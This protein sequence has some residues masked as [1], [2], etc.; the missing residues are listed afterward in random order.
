M[1]PRALSTGLVLLPVAD[2]LPGERRW[3][4]MRLT[5]W[6]TCCFLV[7]F[8]FQLQMAVFGLGLLIFLAIP[9]ERWIRQ[10]GPAMAA[11]VPVPILQQLFGRGS[12]AW[13]EAAR[14]RSQH[15]LVL[16]EWYEWLGII[17]PMFL[18]W[19]WS[20]I[21]DRRQERV[22]AWFNRRI[23][24]YS[25]LVLAL[26]GA[27]ILPPAF[28]RITP[29]Q[30][31]RMFTFVYLYML[32]VG[33]GLLGQF[34]LHRTVWRW[35]VLFVPLATGM[36]LVERSLFPASPHIE[37]PGSTPNNPW[38]QA[39]VWV[40]QNT[41]QDAYFALNPHYYALPD[42]DNRG[43]RGWAQRSQLADWSKD[44]G[45]ASLA[46]SLAPRWQQEV[47]ALDNWPQFQGADFARLHREYAVTWTI[48][49]RQLPKGNSRQ[50]PEILDCPYQNRDLYVCKI[51]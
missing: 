35:L 30:P 47:H 27:L 24:L 15:Y 13:Q 9:W 6:C 17:A 28:E 12:P 20:K 10:M 50:V 31:M 1:H 44:G 32:L 33:G 4:G 5:L 48:L 38:V 34:V 49:E 39:F 22:L 41:P 11:I 7:A 18:L 21:A 43:F 40:R 2:L 37:W 3:R 8:I 29:F 26:G 14:T 46:P 16:W 23:A 25:A 19:W 51:R 45:V 36:Y 42:E